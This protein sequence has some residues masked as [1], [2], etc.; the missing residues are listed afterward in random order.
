MKESKIKMLV[1]CPHPV[2]TVPGQRLK[3]EQ[4]FDFFRKNNIEISVEPFI[5]EKFHSII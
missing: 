5:S 2:N 4:Y 3:Y 1:I